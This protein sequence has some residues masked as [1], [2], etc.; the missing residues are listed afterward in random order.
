MNSF[1]KIY[2]DKIRFHPSTTWFISQCTEARGQYELW[3]NIRPETLKILKESALIQSVESSN[4]IEGVEVERGRL[5]PLIL[6]KSKAK[7]RPEEEIVGYKKAL[8]FIHK[9][10]KK[11]ELSPKLIK[12]LHAIC[13]GGTTSDAGIWKSKDNQ[14]L[15]FLPNGEKF[16]RFSPTSAKETPQAIKE[17]CDNYN[18]NIKNDTFPDIVL[19]GL[20]IFDFLCIHPF[21]D[22]NGRV[23]RLLTELLLMQNNYEVGKYISLERLIEESKESYYLVLK[24]S[25]QNWKSSQHDF[26][27]WLNF[28]LGTVRNGY[29]ELKEKIDYTQNKSKT[30]STLIQE[31]ILNQINPFS[32]LEICNLMPNTDRELIKKVIF[33]LRDQKKLKALGKGRA[34][35]WKVQT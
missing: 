24:E 34:S 16:V 23:S 18:S 21:R 29:K 3:K 1:K 6:G 33:K 14:I 25:S 11:T 10:F 7:D 28:F 2:L 27:P 4:R 8:S 19:I 35:K 20:F 32:V 13:Q 5:I 30:Q 9:D 26:M 31:I 17:L 22:G 15:E 12:K